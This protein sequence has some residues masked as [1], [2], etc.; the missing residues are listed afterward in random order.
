MPMCQLIFYID[1]LSV[2]FEIYFKFPGNYQAF[3]IIQNQIIK[4][5][6]D[7]I[8][9]IANSMHNSLCSTLTRKIFTFEFKGNPTI[10]IITHLSYKDPK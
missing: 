8:A 10:Q 1:F 5:Q 2:N 7:F 3:K 6:M 9:T 4:M